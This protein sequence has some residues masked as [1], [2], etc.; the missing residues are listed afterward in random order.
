M[1]RPEGSKRMVIIRPRAATHAVLTTPDGKK[2]MVGVDDLDCLSGSPGSVTWFKLTN[3]IREQL[4]TFE[5]D[6]KIEEITSD[7]QI[8][9]KRKRK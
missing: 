2:S 1:V 9:R 3:K 7:Y 8:R 4:S 5:F 6:G